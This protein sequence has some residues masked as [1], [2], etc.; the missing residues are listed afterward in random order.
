MYSSVS[1]ALRA[2]YDGEIETLSTD[3]KVGLKP[4]PDPTIQTVGWF[5]KFERKGP[6]TVVPDVGFGDIIRNPTQRMGVLAVRS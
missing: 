5:S 4:F 3:L 1:E 6:R 2:A